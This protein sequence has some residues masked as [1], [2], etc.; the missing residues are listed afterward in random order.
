ME[1]LQ[2]DGFRAPDGTAR[3]GAGVVDGIRSRAPASMPEPDPAQAAAILRL[4]AA[5]SL[6]SQLLAVVD[7]SGSMKERWP[8]ASPGSS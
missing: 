5:L 6:D 1:A 7:V 2:S 8:R 3:E 4:W